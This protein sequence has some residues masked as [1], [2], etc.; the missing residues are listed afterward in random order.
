MS[1]YRFDAEKS[2]L[3]KLY[4]DTTGALQTQPDPT[5]APRIGVVRDRTAP[6]A[7]EGWLHADADTFTDHR[8]SDYVVS[9][10]KFQ[11][12]FWFGCYETDGQHDYEIRAA[13][14]DDGHH[15][16]KYTSHRLD[17]SRNGY[18]GVYS[19]PEEPGHDVLA[20]GS[21]I[22]RL[23]RLPTDKLLPGRA[24]GPI[25][26]VSLH[27]KSVKRLNED[28][29]PYL[30]ENSGGEGWLFIEIIQVGVARP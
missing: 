7:S 8:A 10:R 9:R 17:V 27:G 14:V 11:T 6:W 15:Q 28:G 16:W 24:Y 13:G 5:R 19:T 29:F 22:W 21:M 3:A 18:L 23:E 30:N 20:N 12:Q 1:H 26:L 4:W 25:R 2:F